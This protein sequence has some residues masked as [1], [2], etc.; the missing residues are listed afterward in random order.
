MSR[1]VIELNPG[2][3]SKS[4]MIHKDVALPEKWGCGANGDEKED[5]EMGM[6]EGGEDVEV[7]TEAEGKDER[8]LVGAC[9]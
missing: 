4:F 5:E 1:L 3:L 7:S 2:S 8:A 6:I 9:L